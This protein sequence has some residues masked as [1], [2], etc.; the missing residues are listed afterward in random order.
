MNFYPNRITAALLALGSTAL[1]LQ[2]EALDLDP[3]IVTASRTAESIDQTL[4]PV[5]VITREEIEQKQA[6]SVPE[7]LR[8][9]PGIS[10]TQ[11]GG[12]GSNTSISIRGTNSSQ[13][14]VLVDGVRIGSATNGQ[15]SL[16]SISPEQIERI[17]VVRGPRSSIWGSDAIGGVI[18][19][20]TRKAGDQPQLT[21]KAGGGSH[22][23]QEYAAH[24]SVRNDGTA[25]AV[26]G[27][28]YATGGIDH[29]APE[30]G[31]GTGAMRPNSDHDAY[32]NRNGY[33]RLEQELD[34]LTRTGFS[35]TH[36]EGRSEY[37]DTSNT[38][39]FYSLFRNSTLSTFL[40]RQMSDIWFSRI[41]LG[42]S[43]D[44]NRNRTK[45]GVTDSEFETTRSSASLLN[46]LEWYTG[47]LLTF[48]IDFYEDEVDGSTDYIDPATQKKVDARYN[49][50]FFLQ[51]RTEFDHSDL[52]L[53]L[54]RDK[55]EQFG[56][57]TTGNI[58]YGLDLPED[59]RLIASFGKA[60][61][62]PTFNDLY[63]PASPWSSG[64][65]NLQPETSY[66]QELE[67]RGDHAIGRWSINL[68]RN[69]IDNMISW[70]E[71][72]PWFWQPSNIDKAKIKGVE[73][74]L[75]RVMLGW[76]ARL[77]AVVQ[78]P[79]QE[80][81]QGDDLDL[82]RVPRQKFNLDL[83]RRFDRFSIGGTWSV[84]RYSYDNKS[85]STRNS[86]FG[87]V[88]LRAAYQFDPEWRTELKV[89]NLFDKAYST[90]NGYNGMDRGAYVS[91]VY[92]PEL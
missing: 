62:A 11:N 71:T 3:V 35:L 68:Y 67:L 44:H 76:D 61:R 13:T 37:D 36:N 16:Q 29:T 43:R 84:Q 31:S 34:A 32:R 80:I 41:N 72:S 9:L 25:I 23:T 51:N 10:L 38:D 90:A 17:E 26:G 79:R 92:T 75:Q 58:A 52:Q 6:K 60:Y 33:L 20:F 24:Y 85:N 8:A 49:W 69:R 83:D 70:A 50:A 14:L 7:L 40:E 55:N 27:A 87:T 47:N 5:S 4:A 19:I 65:P 82:I 89:E 39:A 57:V 15:A 59:M 53:G 63:W 28:Y 45:A 66:N 73:L 2:A 54:R 18:Q 21:L 46:D 64:N 1:P 77:S 48:G 81:E 12:P 78:S 91:V 42:Y 56:Y 30:Y 74:A 22:K 86:G 88:D